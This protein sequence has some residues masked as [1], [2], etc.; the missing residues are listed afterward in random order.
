MF[1]HLTD[2]AYTRN[3]TQATTFYIA[4]VLFTT[5]CGGLVG[6]LAGI[7]MHP[8][9]DAFQIGIVLGNV[10]AV[11]IVIVLTG[12]IL[13]KKN[14]THK[15]TNLLFIPVAGLLAVIGGSLL[16]MICVSYLTTRKAHP[17]PLHEPTQ[18]T[19]EL[20]TKDHRPIGRWSFVFQPSSYSLQI[21]FLRGTC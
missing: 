1:T 10:I 6:G 2:F 20:P 9:Q 21:I 17:N 15:A 19:D 8:N 7:V 3:A 18:E 11:L 16:G 12:I 5:V 14:L 4:Y 13:K